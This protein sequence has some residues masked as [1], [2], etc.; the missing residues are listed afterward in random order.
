MLQ[1]GKRTWEIVHIIYIMFQIMWIQEFQKRS[2]REVA[3]K[4][5]VR[6]Y[7]PK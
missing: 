7:K 6:A 4:V 3:K 5:R 1:I 2:G